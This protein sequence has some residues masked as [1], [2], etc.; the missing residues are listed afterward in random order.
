LSIGVEFLPEFMAVSSSAVAPP[1][2]LDFRSTVD[3][4]WYS[5]IVQLEGEESDHIILRVMF[6]NFSSSFDETFGADSFRDERE[7]EE[8]KKR[9]RP[10]AVQ[11]QD[12][13]CMSVVRGT[14]V[15]TAAALEDGEF[16]FY[17]AIVASVS[18]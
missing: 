6:L 13:Q 15:L 10:P 2:M 11:L 9:F 3:D 4:A 14:R 7:V 16:K 8:V 18:S 5:A 12:W 17:D 1:Y